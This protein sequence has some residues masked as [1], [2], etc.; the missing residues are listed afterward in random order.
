[1]RFI[2]GDILE[3]V[4]DGPFDAIVSRLVLMYVSNPASVL[5]TQSHRLRPGGIVVP[6]EFDLPSAR[7]LPATPLVAQALSWLNETFIRA[8]VETSLG[9]RLWT[10]VADACPSP[11]FAASKMRRKYR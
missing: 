6:I 10:V 11:I 7:S 9:T 1:V 8:G 3:P 2:A 4:A 5:R